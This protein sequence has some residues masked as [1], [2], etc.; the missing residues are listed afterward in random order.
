MSRVGEVL[1]SAASWGNRPNVEPGVVAKMKNGLVYIFLVST[2]TDDDE[3]EEFEYGP[4]PWIATGGMTPKVDDPCFVV[5]AS[6]QTAI[7]LIYP[8]AQFEA[9]PDNL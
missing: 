8:K 3:T 4:Y 6:D 2:T 9:L 5:F 7:A 1:S